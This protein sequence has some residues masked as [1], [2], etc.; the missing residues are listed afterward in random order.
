MGCLRK[1]GQDWS[2]RGR[3]ALSHFSQEMRILN[4]GLSST[5]KITK[6][7]YENGFS[8]RDNPSKGALRA[9][10][11]INSAYIGML[12]EKIGVGQVFLVS[13]TGVSEYTTR[14]PKGKVHFGLPGLYQ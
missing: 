5:N 1:V 9:Y 11:H 8:K 2:S 4:R 13:I 6:R 3:D 12:V 10:I 7:V 14:S